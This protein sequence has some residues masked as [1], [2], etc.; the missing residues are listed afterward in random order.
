MHGRK[1]SPSRARS[2][3]PES[4][5]ACQVR[6]P[7]L[8]GPL[9]ELTIIS[10]AT[11]RFVLNAATRLGEGVRAKAR[12]FDDASVIAVIYVC[13]T[14]RARPGEA[15]PLSGASGRMNLASCDGFIPT[16]G[17]RRRPAPNVRGDTQ[18]C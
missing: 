2:P 17:R 5:L 10:Q 6:V 15:W 7:D 9:S 18:Y 13:D 8:P 14:K 3:T 1:L 12:G 11:A 4:D 16:R